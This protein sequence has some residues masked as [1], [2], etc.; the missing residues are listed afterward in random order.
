AENIGAKQNNRNQTISTIFHGDLNSDEP[1]YKQALEKVIHHQEE[2]DHFVVSNEMMLTRLLNWGIPE[3]KVSRIPIGVDT[4]VFHPVSIDEKIK[5]RMKLGIPENSICIGSFL[6]DGVGWEEGHEPKLIK[7]PDIFLEV[8]EKIHQQYPLHILLS[9]PA[10][11]YIKHGLEK[12]GVTYSHVI[13]ENYP[14]LASLYQ[15]IDICLVTSREE[16]GPKSVVEAP[17][18]GIPLVSTRV[19]MAPDLIE[20]KFNGLLADSEDVTTLVKNIAMLIE[21]INLRNKIVA[22]GLDDVKQYD[23]YAIADQYYRMVYQPIL[24]INKN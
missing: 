4:E 7:G 15:A 2:I 23:W 11:G 16:G 1:H 5:L 19:G 20:H 21:D 8:I 10:R 14:E 12:I 13:L 24:N 22:N 17:A 3:A 6:K 9:A 18:C